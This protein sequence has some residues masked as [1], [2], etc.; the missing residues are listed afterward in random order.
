V[1]SCLSDLFLRTGSECHTLEEEKSINISLTA[2][3]KCIN[4]LAE[5]SFH[6]PICDT[7]LTR[8]AASRLNWR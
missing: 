3:G 8:L 6:V 1:S 4:A 7:K 5:I 2:L